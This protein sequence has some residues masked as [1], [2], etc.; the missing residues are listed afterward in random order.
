MK[1]ATRGFTLIELMIVIAIIGIL[2]AALFPAITNY[3]GR[4]RDASR[5]AGLNDISKALTNYAND[6]KETYP[7]TPLD[8]DLSGSI[9]QFIGKPVID[10]LKW[11]DN[12]CG[13]NGFYA[14]GTGYIQ[15]TNHYSISAYLE[16]AVWGYWDASGSTNPFTGTLD[17]AD[18]NNLK[19]NLTKGSGPLYVLFQ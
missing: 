9:L 12:G 18:I 6:Q 1:F 17:P 19:Y 2:A 14:Y 15:I 3:I 11:R 13:P 7:S 4:W 5:I 16:N 8:C 10:P